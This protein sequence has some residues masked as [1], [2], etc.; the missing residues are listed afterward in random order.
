MKPANTHLSS[1]FLSLESVGLLTKPGHPAP[2]APQTCTE[3]RWR[4]GPGR[5]WSGLDLPLRRPRPALGVAALQVVRLIYEFRDGVG[6]G[7]SG[8]CVLVPSAGHR[9]TLGD[10]YV[11][12]QCCCKT[13]RTVARAPGQCRAA[14][15]KVHSCLVGPDRPDQTRRF[16]PALC[17]VR[18]AP[19]PRPERTDTNAPLGVGTNGS[20]RSAG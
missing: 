18:N 7:L 11:H 8:A 19:P 13:R 16:C 9:W 17:P 10:V 2:P 15:T 20:R 5:A 4:S 12:A 14:C 1:H 3:W 6:V